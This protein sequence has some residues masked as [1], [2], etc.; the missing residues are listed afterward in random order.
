MLF[1]T[2]KDRVTYAVK[3][4][5]TERSNTVDSALLI[6]YNWMSSINVEEEDISAERSTLA[7][8]ILN[9]WTP[10]HRMEHDLLQD[11]YPGKRSAR[12]G[13]GSP[14]DSPAAWCRNTP[15]R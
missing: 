8:R 11:L 6:L 5:P 2:G 12:P 14:A 9:S 4:I 1:S 13:S 15:L 7:G 10:M 3:D